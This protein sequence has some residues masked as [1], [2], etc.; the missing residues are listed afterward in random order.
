MHNLRYFLIIFDL[1][2]CLNSSLDRSFL[3]IRNSHSAFN[4]GTGRQ[5]KFKVRYR[6]AFCNIMNL[7]ESIEIYY[8]I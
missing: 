2:Y 8:W 7:T 6:Y 5:N 3:P 1:Q 4:T